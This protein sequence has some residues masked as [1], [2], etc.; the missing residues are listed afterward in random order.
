MRLGPEPKATRGFMGWRE[1]LGEL[2]GFGWVGERIGCICRVFAR[3]SDILALG[4]QAQGA[5]LAEGRVNSGKM[6][7]VF[8]I[9]RVYRG[10]DRY[11]IILNGNCSVF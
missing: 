11:Y 10:S 3:V 8:G 4:S 6:S 7:N 1:G 9:E 2:T 5:E